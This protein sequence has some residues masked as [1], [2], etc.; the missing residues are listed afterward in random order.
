V[1]SVATAIAC[2]NLPPNSS[3][4]A[5]RARQLIIGC[6][7]AGSRRRTFSQ[8]SNNAN[9]SAVVNASQSSPATFS[10]AASSAS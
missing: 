6:S 5:W 1:I 8:R 3:A 7:A 2:A 10:A 4:V 9:H